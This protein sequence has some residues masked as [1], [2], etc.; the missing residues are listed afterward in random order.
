MKVLM[1]NY[2]FPPL[3]GGAGNATYYLLKKFSRFKD[4]EIDLVTSSMNKYKE[5]QFSSNVKIYYLN[6]GKKNKNLHYQTNKNLFLYSWKAYFK[7]K[8]LMAKKNYGLIHAF[9]GIPCGVI[10]VLLKKP[11]I[12]SL[13]GSDVPFFNLRFYW[14][15]RL[16]FKNINKIIWARAKFVVVNSQ[17]LKKLAL[18]ISLNQRIKII[19]NGVNSGFFIPKP[20]IKKDNIILF[21]GRLIS[22]KGIRYLLEAFASLE[23]EYLKNWQI[24]LVG[25]GPEKGN[26]FCQAKNLNILKR[27]KFL[28]IKN[29]HELVNIYN[30]AKIFVLP[31]LS[32]GMSNAVLEA[33]ACGL[34]IIMSRVGGNEE[35]IKNNGFVVKKKSALGIKKALEKYLDN[36]F[37]VIKHSAN[38]QKIVK[39]MSWK[40]I[41]QQ[42]FN[43]YLQCVE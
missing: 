31:S 36:N 15:D 17:G 1:L 29:K 25:D 18:S 4:L 30:Q 40:K 6:I 3:G 7:A 32:E 37:L 35:L 26:L 11:Y 21:V 10:A 42:Y 41:A 2:E 22:R 19:P 8:S 23:K 38:S 34:P 14:L 33:M 12:V 20:K 27:V 28:G 13:R 43:L 5:E 9:F 24:W 16:F 39:K